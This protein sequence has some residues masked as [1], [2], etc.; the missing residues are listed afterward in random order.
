MLMLIVIMAMKKSHSRIRKYIICYSMSEV[1][2][3]R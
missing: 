1:A 2:H 3:E